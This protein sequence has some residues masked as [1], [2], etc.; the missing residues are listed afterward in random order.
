MAVMVSPH[1][2]DSSAV[3]RND[4]PGRLGCGSVGF[5]APLGFFHK[6][7]MT[8]KEVNAVVAL[9]ARYGW[10]SSA[11]ARNDRQGGLGCGSV[12]FPARLGF[13]HKVGMTDKED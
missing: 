12:G 4:R 2:W 6:V 5:P 8:D 9:V 11:D 13:L 1:G 3:A 10:D 7:G